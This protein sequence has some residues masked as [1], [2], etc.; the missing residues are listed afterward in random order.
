MPRLGDLLQTFEPQ[1]RALGERNAIQLA[2]VRTPAFELQRHRDLVIY[3]APVDWLWPTARIAV[4]GIT[5][6]ANTMLIAHRTAA[7]RLA[8]GGG[9]R[10]ALQAVKREAPFSGFRPRLVERLDALGVA[11]HLGVAS[12]AALF[13]H[14]HMRLL[15]ATSVVR[16]PAFK[17]SENYSGQSPRLL[18]RRGILRRYV[19][20]VLAPELAL[21]P[22]ALVV[23][24]GDRV[25]EALSALAA[26]ELLDPARCLVGFPHPSGLNR[27]SD[28][29]WK[30]NHARLKRQVNRW[31]RQ[32]P[33]ELS[34]ATS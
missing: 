20:D 15:H 12:S 27:Y 3:Y 34:A 30:I 5:P 25:D 4:V 33:V 23:P 14:P 28:E 21:I 7:R 32:H 16:Y 17:N 9:A 2:D 19:Y 24:L 22:Q 26:D 11:R 13:E 8:D 1:I 18:S 6:S 29:R 31:F 10:A